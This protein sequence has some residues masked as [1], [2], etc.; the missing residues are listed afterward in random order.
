MMPRM[1][2]M[3][4]MAWLAIASAAGVGGASITIDG[5][6]SRP[7]A[8]W[9]EQP[10]TSPMRFKQFELPRVKG[11]D[12]D[13]ELAIFFFGAGQ[14]GDAEANVARW[15]TLF[16]PPAGKSIDEVT[17]VTTYKVGPVK[18]THVD[19][20]SGT[21][22]FKA[23]PVDPALPGERRPG[24]RMFGVVWESKNGPYFMRLVG[25]EKTVAHYKPGFD[26]WLKAFK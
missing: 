9:K 3:L 21:Y 2:G 8:E 14:G 24:H 26:A 4:G 20:T 6:S 12:R 16:E 11:D 25:P 5:L 23:R 18:V 15:K 17:K 1:L 19:I 10:T 13:A 22:L 7:P